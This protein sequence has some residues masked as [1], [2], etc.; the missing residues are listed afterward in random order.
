MT[1]SQRGHINSY[2]VVIKP[3]ILLNHCEIWIVLWNLIQFDCRN[4]DINYEICWKFNE[5]WPTYFHIGQKNWSLS[6]FI[7]LNLLEGTRGHLIFEF[8]NL[9][10]NIYLSLSCWNTRSSSAIHW[11]GWIGH[12]VHSAVVFNY[13]VEIRMFHGLHSCQS[14]L[15]IIPKEIQSILVNN[16]SLNYISKHLKWKQSTRYLGNLLFW[17]YISINDVGTFFRF[18]W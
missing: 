5:L 15:V 1:A 12:C 3:Q 16:E 18:Y 7:V 11:C 14:L 13:R 4:L 2:V 6:I 9:F 17:R 10:L 8:W